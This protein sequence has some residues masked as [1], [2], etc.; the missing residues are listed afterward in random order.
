MKNLTYTVASLIVLI[1]VASPLLLESED[2]ITQYVEYDHSLE[3]S[4]KPQTASRASFMMPQTDD[5]NGGLIALIANTESHTWFVKLIGTYK[6]VK[7]QIE[8]LELVIKTLDLSHGDHI[9]YDVPS[10]WT[11]RR[12]LQCAKPVS[13]LQ[14]ALIFL[15]KLPSGQDVKANVIRWKK[16]IGLD[17][18]PTESELIELSQIGSKL[19]F[20]IKT[21]KIS[22]LQRIK[23]QLIRQSK[24]HHLRC[25]KSIKTQM[26]S[27]QQSLKDPMQLGSSN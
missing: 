4:A 14:V 11:K 7:A 8:N 24:L 13:M 27:W 21:R 26:Q 16:Q 25:L 18:A 2:K 12:R 1:I 3:A 6:S 9:H 10:D 5:K 23:L 22:S 15:S 20:L 19:F 17:G